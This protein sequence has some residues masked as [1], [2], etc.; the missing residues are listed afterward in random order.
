[1]VVCVIVLLFTL[2]EGAMSSPKTMVKFLHT[3]FYYSPE[4]SSRYTLIY[5]CLK[6]F[7]QGQTENMHLE[8]GGK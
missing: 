3:T 8:R 1:M 7:L 6:I 4:D 5:Y 2:E